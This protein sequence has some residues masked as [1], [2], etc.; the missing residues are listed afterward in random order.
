MV[1]LRKF[2][3]RVREEEEEEEVEEKGWVGAGS[4]TLAGQHAK[5]SIRRGHQL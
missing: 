5:F 2:G 1:I 4:R 3:R